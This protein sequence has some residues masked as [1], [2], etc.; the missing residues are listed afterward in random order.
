MA[1]DLHRIHTHVLTRSRTLFILGL[2][3]LFCA[4]C[5]AQDPEQPRG[6]GEPVS[7]RQRALLPFSCGGTLTRLTK[8]HY[9]NLEL[10]VT[11]YFCVTNGTPSEYE[12][13][14][15][16]KRWTFDELRLADAAAFRNRY[17]RLASDLRA[18]IARDGESVRQLA[19]VW[20]P[21]PLQADRK[22]PPKP[23]FLALSKSQQMS[24]IAAH[25]AAVAA[26]AREVAAMIHR[27]APGATVDPH[28]FAFKGQGPLL[29]V[30]AAPADLRAIGDQDGILDVGLS[31]RKSEDQPT[32]NAWFQAGQFDVMQYLGLDGDGVSVADVLGSPGVYDTRYLGT[33][34]GSCVPKHGSNYD[35]YCSASSP[36]QTGPGHMQYVL[37]IIDNTWQQQLGGT[38]PSGSARHAATLAGNGGSGYCGSVYL[39]DLVP[40][41]VSHG[42]TVVNRSATN[43][44]S[45]S[46]YLDCVAEGYSCSGTSGYPSIVASA[47]NSGASI[48]SHL[49]N[50]L[51]VGAV[52][53]HGSSD[54]ASVTMADFSAWQNTDNAELPHLVAPGVN[55]NVVSDDGSGNPVQ[56]LFGGTSAAAPQVSG[57]IASLQESNS[58]LKYWPEAVIPVMLVSAFTDTDPAGPD[59][60]PFDLDDGNDDM[61]GAG[62]LATGEAWEVVFS[63]RKSPGNAASTRGFDYGSYSPST[64]PQGTWLYP[65]YY[66][67]VPAGAYL[68]VAAFMLNHPVC[69]TPA[70]QSNCTSDAFPNYQLYVW[71]TSTG[72]YMWSSSAGN[73]YK[74]VIIWNTASTTQ[75]FG[76][77]MFMGTWAGMSYDTWGLA[78]D[79]Q[80]L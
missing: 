68:R 37:S 27:V 77:S 6:P 57:A 24:I 46:R 69:G 30:E 5:T 4:A 22:L 76:I 15:T 26:R 12:V 34:G 49:R 66:A 64:W 53:D 79:S 32:S 33:A 9:K 35:C 14:S 50:G 60:V 73:N 48:Q 1:R 17:H 16:G 78:W 45:A 8:L 58:S 41:A 23:E 19:D 80:V 29:Q 20:F 36:T 47:G 21:T 75:T 7:A 2:S 40:W 31:L 52:D 70:T 72:Y 63:G 55:I 44:V 74:Y 3:L 61:D 62:L 65:Y 42:A 67:S 56:T 51:V 18:R 10:D 39:E 25:N 59:G 11:P 43:G 54:R 38:L 71:N 28:S 13:D